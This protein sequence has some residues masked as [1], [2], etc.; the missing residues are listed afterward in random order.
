MKQ[1]H[2]WQV[3]A[4]AVQAATLERG[5]QAGQLGGRRAGMQPS[6]EG[7]TDGGGPF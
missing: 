6:S 5:W 1:A 3:L 7:N 2:I 4:S